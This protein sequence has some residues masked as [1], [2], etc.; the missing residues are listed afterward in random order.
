MLDKTLLEQT[1]RDTEVSATKAKHSQ[2]NLL[3]LE[4]FY[5]EQD[6]A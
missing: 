1:F 6:F 4:V 3:E 2:H 5:T